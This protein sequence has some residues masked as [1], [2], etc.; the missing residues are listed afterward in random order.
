MT[1]GQG[2]L[3]VLHV[4]L[5]FDKGGLEVVA[6]NLVRLL[7]GRGYP[8]AVLALD[9]GGEIADLARSE[10]LDVTVLGGRHFWSLAFHQ[11]VHSVLRK[12][13]PRV[14]HTHHPSALLHALPAGKLLGGARWVHT[15]HSSRYFARAPRMRPLMR[16]ASRAVD[17]F[18]TVAHSAEALYVNEIRV[19]PDR[20]RVVPNGIDTERF[21]P[22]SPTQRQEVR[23]QL[24]LKGN[25]LV[26]AAGRLDKV[27]DLG[28]LIRS[29]AAALP[30]CPDL[31]VV[32]IGD[33]DEREALEKQA[34]AAGLGERVQFVGWRND[35]ERFFKALDVFA[36]SS[37]TEAL[38]LALLEGMASGLPVV[39]TAVGDVTEIVAEAGCGVT[40][41]VGDEVGFGGELARFLADPGLRAQAGQAARSFVQAHY[42][43]EAMVAGYLREYAL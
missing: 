26:G 38:P 40:V 33:G 1:T 27:K 7:S 17:S 28:L 15:E 24:G 16:L 25:P 20:L 31:G 36:L 9:G 10:G 5:A 11:R 35:T 2:R 29:A 6:L 3:A 13:R 4:V 37:T 22:A 34:A 14:I 39:A 18:V 8:S 41:T 42:S 21:S 12:H 23:R 43:I 32:L 30:S 19:P